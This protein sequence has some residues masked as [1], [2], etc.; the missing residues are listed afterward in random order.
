MAQIHVADA[1]D[2]TGG[3]GRGLKGLS[4]RTKEESARL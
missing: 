2:D 4:G 3:D 1:L